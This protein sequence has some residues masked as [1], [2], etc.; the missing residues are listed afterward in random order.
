MKIL[1][2]IFFTVIFLSPLVS[3]A[4]PGRTDTSGCH[5]CKTNCA[6]WSLST[7][8]YHCHGSKST[9]SSTK[10]VST[11]IVTTSDQKV[12]NII[13]TQESLYRTSPHGFREK[14]IEKISSDLLL[15]REFVAGKVYI[16]LPDIK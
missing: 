6:K 7:G 5:T 9:L 11:P 13:A 14:L 3:L 16:L 15:S 8:E 1:R 2:I 12:R 10:T 4:H